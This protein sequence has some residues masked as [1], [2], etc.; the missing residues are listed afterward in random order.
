[1]NKLKANG[2]VKFHEQQKARSSAILG[3]IANP[4]NLPAGLWYP[5]LLVCGEGWQAPLALPR[6]SPVGR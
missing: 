2:V 1:M 6:P 5:R 3:N 4:A